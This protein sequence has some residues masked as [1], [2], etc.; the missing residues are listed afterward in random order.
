MIKTQDLR[1]SYSN[2]MGFEFPNISCEAKDEVLI[3]GNSGVG[4]STLLHLLAGLMKP[5]SGSIYV[6][7]Q[8]I[9]KL[10]GK[11]MDKFRGDNIGIIFQKNHFVEALNVIENLTLAQFLAGKKEDR[12][13]AS[14]L[15]SRLN[16]GSKV[17]Q[18]INRLS[19]G[20]KQRVAIARAL[21]NHPK[22]ILADEPT[23]ALDDENC[24]VVVKLL[25]EQSEAVGASL[26]IVTHDNRL[27][28]H[29]ANQIHLKR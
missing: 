5:T 10:S 23:S 13:M 19:Q 15:L 2:D 29:V 25:E 18:K 4:K 9:T 3:L 17:D 11:A 28:E 16:I 7:D 20:E 14:S 24:D 1:F 21:I 12:A 26:V 22:L 6:G 8:D 27:K